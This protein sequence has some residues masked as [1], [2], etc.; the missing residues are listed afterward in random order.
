[1]KTV[2]M[3]GLQMVDRVEYLHR[4]EVIHGDVKPSNFLVGRGKHRHKVY[5]TDFELSVPFMRNGKHIPEEFR[6]KF[7]GSLRF[8]SRAANSR[9]SLSR[10]DDLESLLY[11]LIFLVKGE[12][13]WMKLAASNMINAN[14]EL[15][16]LKSNSRDDLLSGLPEAFVAAVNY[17][18]ELKFSSAPDYDRL[19]GMFSGLMKKHG[20]EMDYKYDWEYL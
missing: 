13:P 18:D 7:N 19:R 17:I 11:S 15:L 4:N 10:R 8:S 3:V 14:E 5:L 20:Y 1:L 2:V 6:D 12:L 9:L 16:A